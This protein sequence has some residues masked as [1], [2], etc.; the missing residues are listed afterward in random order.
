MNIRE[1]GKL[2][3]AAS[4]LLSLPASVSSTSTHR[5]RRRAR[6]WLAQR[7][8][9]LR[10]RWQHNIGIALDARQDRLT[11]TLTPLLAPIERLLAAFEIS[12]R[13]KGAD[14]TV[15]GLVMQRGA[16]RHDSNLP[17]L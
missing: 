16:K 4:P 1:H 14:E 13:G 12:K 2:W 3:H 5:L 8:K 7:V 15:R 17:A 11:W 6:G 10:M 9:Q